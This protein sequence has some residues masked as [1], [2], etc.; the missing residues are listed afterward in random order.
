MVS[1][2]MKN[3]NPAL[4]INRTWQRALSISMDISPK[5]KPDA[6]LRSLSSEVSFLAAKGQIHRFGLPAKML[7]VLN[8]T[9]IHRGKMPDL[10]GEG[11]VYHNAGKI[12]PEASQYQRSR[13]S[14]T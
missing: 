12:L 1:R 3:P 8:I 6:L 4:P 9:E 10:S 14:S 2:I 11:F 7:A 13:L 5:G